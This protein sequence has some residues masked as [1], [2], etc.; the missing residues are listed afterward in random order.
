MEFEGSRELAAQRCCR[1]GRTAFPPSGRRAKF[2]L[3]ASHLP[4]ARFPL[5]PVR[6]AYRIPPRARRGWLHGTLDA[7]RGFS[8]RRAVSDP[9]FTRTLALR[10][11]RE[12]THRIRDPIRGHHA[13]Y[14]V[15]SLT[16]RD[17]KPSSDSKNLR[18]SKNEK[19]MGT[20]P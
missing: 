4:S 1:F 16:N 9:P 14:K 15:E 7:G 5:T 17:H 6:K 19:I 13:V 18:I 10:A 12:V 8:T 2:H 11:G 3:H 20:C